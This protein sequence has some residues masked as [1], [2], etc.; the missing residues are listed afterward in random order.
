LKNLHHLLKPKASHS[1]AG[2]L[3]L[4]G[5]RKSGEVT[6][7]S[8]KGDGEIGS[9]MAIADE[10]GMV[11]GRLDNPTADPPLRDDGKLNVG[12]AVGQGILSV[13]RSYPNPDINKPY[14]GVV[15]IV[16]GEIAEDLANYLV[17]SEQTNSALGLGVSLNRDCSVKSAG[18]FLVQILP[19]CSEETLT[20]LEQNLSSLPSMTAMLNQGLSADDITD[21]ILKGL[22]GELPPDR[23]Y[24]EPKYGPCDEEGLRERMMRAVAMLGEKE[25]RDIMRTEGKIEVTCEFCNETAQFKE[26]DILSLVGNV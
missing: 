15:P 23:I 13:I 14:T 9:I 6:Q 21:L 2:T 12:A 24:L 7:V 5:F 22:V 11:K 3:L 1:S 4:A 8:F 20:I 10:S 18:G 19:F 26:D 16:S 17:D 25:V